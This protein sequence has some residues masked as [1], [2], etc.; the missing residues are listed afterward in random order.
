MQEKLNRRNF[1]RSAAAGAVGLS[2]LS[3]RAGAAEAAAP[4]SKEFLARLPNLMEWAG[5]P[6]IQIGVIEEARLTW[7]GEFGVKNAETKESVTAETVFPA[8]SLSKPVFA[9]AVL[10]LYDEG[11]LDLDRPLIEYLPIEYVPDDPRGKAINARHVLSHSSGLQNW[12]F[13]AA[14]K[15]QLSFSPG[16][17]FSYSGEGFFYLQRVVEKITGL[18]LQQ[19]MRERIFEPLGMRQS[20]YIWRPEYEKT[21]TA[22]HTNRGQ[23][24]PAFGAEMIPKMV[25]L[26]N[27][28]NKPLESWKYEDLERALP[29]LDPK[30]LVFPNFMM[31]N[32]AASMQ[33]T[34][35]DYAR[36]LGLL[37]DPSP[38]AN[39]KLKSETVAEMLKPQITINSVLSWGFGVG[40]ENM[41]GRNYF[42]HWGDNGNYKAFVV[43][44]RA[45]NA[46]MVIFTNGR[47]GHKIWERIVREVTKKD[48][49]SFLWV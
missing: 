10:K 16:T 15:L 37:L 44:D 26:A 19:F 30:M 22:G 8:A 49:A 18:G 48:F 14:D 46:G 39:L 4:L 42:W 25:D 31:M 5:V 3:G 24:R 12:R 21:L 6:G 34:V 38:P 47:N 11:L 2:M 13:Q 1:V 33:T 35:T 20:S 28:W 36:F 9:Y 41:D 29:L 27:K 32:A 7:T 45:K 40:L 43:G 17:G 23:V